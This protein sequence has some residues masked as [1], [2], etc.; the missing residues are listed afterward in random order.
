[1]NKHLY[2]VAGSLLLGL[3]IYFF[4]FDAEKQDW[5]LFLLTGALLNFFLHYRQNLRKN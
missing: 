1:M 3:G 4:L 2:L 5:G